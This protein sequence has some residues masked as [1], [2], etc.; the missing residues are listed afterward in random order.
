MCPYNI[1]VIYAFGR[2]LLSRLYTEL[3][4]KQNKTKQNKKQETQLIDWIMK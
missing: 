1:F 3:K 4:T 2:W